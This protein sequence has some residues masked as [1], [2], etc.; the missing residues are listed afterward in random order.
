MEIMH[1]MS[2]EAN[3]PTPKR[4][5]YSPALKAQVVAQCR[6]D[7]ASIAAVALTHGINAN[8]VHR[9]LREHPAKP[10]P[11]VTWPVE[12]ASSCADGLRDWLR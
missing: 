10:A 5:N 1:T 7:G 8:I 2:S 3:A 4:R 12:P 11:K 6:A 9:W